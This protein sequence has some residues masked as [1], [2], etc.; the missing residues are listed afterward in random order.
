MPPPEWVFG[1]HAKVSN[2]E[3]MVGYMSNYTS[4][5]K[6]PVDSVIMEGSMTDNYDCFTF[7]PSYMNQT[8]KDYLVKENIGVM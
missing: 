8:V 5:T 2:D 1:M 7:H 6:W 4:L 3:D